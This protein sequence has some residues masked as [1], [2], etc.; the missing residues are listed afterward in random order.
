MNINKLRA[1][2][3]AGFIGLSVVAAPAAAQARPVIDEEP[4]V[5][6]V[7]TPWGYLCRII[8]PFC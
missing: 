3:V 6:P 4:Y 8:N 5:G 2:F 7:W 1:A